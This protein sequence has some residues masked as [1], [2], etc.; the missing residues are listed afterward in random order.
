[1]CT[2]NKCKSSFVEKFINY[3]CIYNLH[4]HACKY[5]GRELR[6]YVCHYNK[7]SKHIENLFCKK[8]PCGN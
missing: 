4:V 5:V 1:M 7:Y 8:N 3:L 2:H 6:D